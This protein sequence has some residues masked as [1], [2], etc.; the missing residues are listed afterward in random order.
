MLVPKGWRVSVSGLPIFGGYD[1]K[2]TQGDLP[3]DAPLLRVNATAVF[4]GVGVAN[5]PH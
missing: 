5:E 3:A 1:D 2:T 4:G